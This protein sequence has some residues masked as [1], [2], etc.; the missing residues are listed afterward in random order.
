VRVVEDIVVVG[1]LGCDVV[2]CGIFGCCVGGRIW[3]TSVE[4]GW[5]GW[6]CWG[7][8]VLLEDVERR[9]KDRREVYVLRAKASSRVSYRCAD[10]ATESSM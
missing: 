7:D 2:W 3:C 6:I 10:H 5:L 8:S 1:G 9:G 4:F